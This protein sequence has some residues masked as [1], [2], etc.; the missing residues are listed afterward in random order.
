MRALIALL[1]LASLWLPHTARA[2][3]DFNGAWV[4][5]MCPSGVQRQSGQCA[6]FVLEVLHKGD[7]LCGT[8]MVATA[9][10]SEVEEGVA[11][12]FQAT[13]IRA[14]GAPA[15]AEGEIRSVVRGNML[16]MRMRL[17][18]QGRVLLWERLDSPSGAILL[19]KSQQ[20][21]KAPRATLLA[22]VFEQEL[23]NGCERVF[24]LAA[25]RADAAVPGTDGSG[26]PA[27]RVLGERGGQ[28]TQ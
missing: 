4:G 3:P 17:S 10:A 9:G 12:S 25:A 15:T 2:E 28:G 27:Q 16:A 21:T 7:T 8:H 1:F 24:Q 11:P 20:L 14:D 19:P 22:P 6:N 23:R 5:W 18:A 13:V 26:A